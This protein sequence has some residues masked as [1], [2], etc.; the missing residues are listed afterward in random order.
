MKITKIE[1]IMAGTMF[2]RIHTDN[3]ITGWGWLSVDSP[4]LWRLW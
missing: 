3:G 1:T 2:I 4:K